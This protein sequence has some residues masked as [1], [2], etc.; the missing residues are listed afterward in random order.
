[1]NKSEVDLALFEAA[2]KNIFDENGN[3]R[4]CSVDQYK[5]LIITANNVGTKEYG[6][7]EFGRVDIDEVKKLYLE[8][9]AN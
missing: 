5:N 9:F 7:L 6:D 2:Y 8:L 3:I 4:S 1:M